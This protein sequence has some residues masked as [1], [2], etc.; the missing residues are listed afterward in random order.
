MLRVF[1]S[2]K[3][4]TRPF[5]ASPLWTLWTIVKRCSM[6]LRHLLVFVLRIDFL[7]FLPVP[8]GQDSVRHR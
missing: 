2:R 4:Q 3:E 5:T 1:F 6:L 7:M 8:E